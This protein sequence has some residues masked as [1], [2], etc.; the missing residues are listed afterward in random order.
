MT[1]LRAVTRPAE[2]RPSPGDVPQPR[3][4]MIW[5]GHGGGMVGWGLA[6]S[7]TFSG[8]DRFRQAQEWFDSLAAASTIDDTVQSPG[9]G[10]AAFGTFSFSD[11]SADASTLTIPA[12][13]RGWNEHGAWETLISPAEDTA[14]S[15]EIEEPEPIADFGRV[16]WGPGEVD[17]DRFIDAVAETVEILAD[18]D[19]KKVVLARD[20][21][22][23][24]ERPMDERLLTAR[25]A[26]AFPSCWT[27][28][29]DGLTGATPEMLASVRGGHLKTRVLAGSWPTTGGHEAAEYALRSSAKDI[30][31][32]RYASDSVLHAIDL[33]ASGPVRA[34]GPTILHLPNVVHLSTDFEADLAPGWTGLTAAGA[35]HPTAAVGGTPTDLAL[36]VIA[37]I[38]GLDRG[39]YAAPVGWMDAAGNSD[40]AL[41]LRCAQID[42]TDP[43]RARAL[44][45]GGVM[46]RSVPQ[47]ELAETEA[48]FSAVL[49]AFSRPTA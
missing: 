29:I 17:E 12:R 4:N 6:A 40:W 35:M 7:Q 36:D 42:P 15:D 27:F 20:I 43:H 14:Q 10:L 3:G 21:A 48:K 46:D 49:H 8:P 16:V 23:V 19:I 18:G 25:L 33:Q 39:R 45:G 1:S 5:V 9:T 32:H 28:C 22:I 11:E 24:S 34:D 44:A 13:I 2:R 31:E 30:A 37:R 38:E 47:Q 41:A 26:S